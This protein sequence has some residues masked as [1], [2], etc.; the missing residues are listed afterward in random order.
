V[1]RDNAEAKFWLNPLR[2]SRGR[3]FSERELSA[4]EH[5]L[6]EHREFLLRSWDEFFRRS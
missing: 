6:D 5:L 1:E 2:Y 4:I 3:G